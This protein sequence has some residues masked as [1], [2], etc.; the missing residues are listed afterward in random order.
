MIDEVKCGYCNCVH[1][2]GEYD[3]VCPYVKTELP[4]SPA[5]LIPVTVYVPEDYKCWSAIVTHDGYKKVAC[6]GVE[7]VQPY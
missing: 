1:P 4:V 3:V 5:K 7:V 6:D 2:R